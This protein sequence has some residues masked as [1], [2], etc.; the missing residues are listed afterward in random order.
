MKIT[1]VEPILTS[2]GFIQT[3]TSNFG[4][5][6]KLQLGTG[7]AVSAY[8]SLEGG[9][10]STVKSDEVKKVSFSLESKGT[11]YRCLSLEAL[12]AKIPSIAAELKKV[13][14]TPELLK[15]PQ[16]KTRYVHMKEPLTVG[17][18][19]EPFLSC[20]GMRIVGKGNKKH[21]LCDGVST[22]LPALVIYK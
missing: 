21:T 11:T 19:F 7:F 14:M 22:A 20:E 5:Q 9:F 10:F 8:A 17:K 3:E 13:S 1:E 12:K 18:K 15:C 6:Y 4:H 2:H 16:C